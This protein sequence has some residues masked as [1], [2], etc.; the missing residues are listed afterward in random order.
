MNDI[1]LIQRIKEGDEGA[2]KYLVETYQHIVYNTALNFVQNETDAEDIAQE[3]FIQ[4]HKSINQFKGDSKLST[5]IYRITT[6]KALDHLRNK[7]RKKR[8]AQLTALFG[9]QNEL[10]H[11]AI[12]FNHPAVA[13]DK[14][15]RAAYVFKIVKQ[16][17]E[18]QKTAFILHHIEELPYQEIAVIMSTSVSAIESLLFR[19]RQNLRKSL[20]KNQLK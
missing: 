7:K 19:A 6:T 15:E 16:L 2:F 5:W 12:D 11:D 9:D 18:N 13:I 20:D 10:M 14:K 4:I 8:F 3:V 17:P 1:I